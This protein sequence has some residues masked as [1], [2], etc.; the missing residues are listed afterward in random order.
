MAPVLSRSMATAS[1]ASLPSSSPFAPTRSSSALRSAFLPPQP[2]RRKCFSSAA[3]LKWKN[4]DRRR[5]GGR[6]SVRCDAAVAE[7]EEATGEKFE[8]Q[9]EVSS[10]SIYPIINY[11]FAL[12]FHSFCVLNELKFQSFVI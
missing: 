2:A 10:E 12:S 11:H 3:A 8:Y 1:L 4:N 5:N 7:K 6:L 9:A